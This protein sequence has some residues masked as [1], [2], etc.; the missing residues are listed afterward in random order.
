MEH[1]LN[2]LRKAGLPAWP[3]NFRSW[4]HLAL[5]SRGPL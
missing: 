3:A 1:L 2:D 5:P 4:L